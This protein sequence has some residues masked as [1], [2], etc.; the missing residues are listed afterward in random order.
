MTSGEP[1]PAARRTLAMTGRRLNRLEG[2]LH[3]KLQNSRVTRAV[4]LAEERAQ[5]ASRVCDT[6]TANVVTDDHLVI[7][8]E[9]GVA[10]KELLITSRVC[11]IRDRQVS[12]RVD[13]GELC[14]IEDIKGFQ[15]ELD[16]AVLVRV[17]EVDLFED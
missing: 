15:T 12:D 16:I 10:G 7:S 17:A 2:D 13:A 6:L 9:N 8:G 11:S 4:V 1:P 14:V 3:G 5:R